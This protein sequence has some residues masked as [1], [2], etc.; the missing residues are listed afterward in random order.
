MVGSLVG[1]LVGGMG[2]T[3]SSPPPISSSMGVVVGDGVVGLREGDKMGE[4]DGELDGYGVGDST[5]VEDGKEGKVGVEVGCFVGE[6]VGTIRH[7]CPLHV[8]LQHD[9]SCEDTHVS[10]ATLQDALGSTH[11]SDHRQF[12]LLGPSEALQCHA[13]WGGSPL[14]L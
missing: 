1:I 13:L 3:A 6:V 4:L 7:L 8:P 11:P 14:S 12:C 5:G 9:S 10:P 2:T